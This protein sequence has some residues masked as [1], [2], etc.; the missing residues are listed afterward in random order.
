MYKR[1]TDDNDGDG[2]TVADGDCNDN[3]ATIHPGAEEVCGDGIDQDCDGQD[4]DAIIAIDNLI[5]TVQSLELAQG[6]ETS[7]IAK[8]NAA[9][10][11]LEKGNTKVAKRQLTTFIIQVSALSGKK[12]SEAD[13][14][15][16]IAQAQAIIDCL[17]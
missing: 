15:D 6:T 4:L 12:I 5:A 11:S 14:D 13:A 17:P 8:L 7:L 1:Q 2:F 10:R 3:D 16:L 9:K